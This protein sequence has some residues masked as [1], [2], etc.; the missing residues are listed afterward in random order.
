MAKFHSCQQ[1][2]NL[3]RLFKDKVKDEVLLP[4]IIALHTKCVYTVSLLSKEGKTS[5]CDCECHTEVKANG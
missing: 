3:Y 5:T 2:D 1:A 4:E